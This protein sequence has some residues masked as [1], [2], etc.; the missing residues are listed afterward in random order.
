MPRLLKFAL[1]KILNYTGIYDD[2][3]EDEDS[4]GKSVKQQLDAKQVCKK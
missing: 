3:H 1:S 4:K 2:I